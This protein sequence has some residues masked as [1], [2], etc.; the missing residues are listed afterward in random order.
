MFARIPSHIC[1]ER[2]FWAAE[3]RLVA[4]NFQKSAIEF[5]SS[6]GENQAILPQAPIR[7]ILKQENGSFVVAGDDK[8]LY[9]VNP[10]TWEITTLLHHKKRIIAMVK[11]GDRLIFADRVGGIWDFHEGEAKFLGSHL[12]PITALVTHGDCLI[13]GDEDG[14]ILKWSYPAVEIATIFF[15][16]TTCVTSIHLLEFGFCS[17]D[18]SGIVY[19]WSHDGQT[20]DTLA[21]QKVI[22]KLLEWDSLLIA[23]HPLGYSKIKIVGKSTMTLEE[24]VAFEEEA[25]ELVIHQGKPLPFDLEGR[26][27]GLLTESV[28][29]ISKTFLEAPSTTPN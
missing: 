16:H 24:Y 26:P 28:A 25:C 22:S 19:L 23:L 6:T 9:G 3:N 4:Y 8:V 12:N 20:K 10:E 21:T 5:Q 11:L 13:S 2:L 27:V 7:A 29:P 14:V 17:A 15:G 1:E 18:I